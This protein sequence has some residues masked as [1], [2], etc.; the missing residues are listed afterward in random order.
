VRSWFL[1][2]ASSFVINY[3]HRLSI[4]KH[5]PR[6]VWAALELACCLR[7]AAMLAVLYAG[8]FHWTRAVEFYVL[9][10]FVLGLNYNR[11]LVA[12]HYRNRGE[13]M[14]HQQ[15]LEDSVNITGGGLLT[16]LFFPL[17]LRYHALHHLFPSIP[18]HNLAWAHERLVRQ[19][20]EDSLY[21]TT[22]FASY[23][24]VLAELWA[25]ARAAGTSPNPAAA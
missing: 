17:G 23:W 5:A 21:H 13:E 18:Y 24:D 19:L 2:H 8:V 11:N 4:S 16:E 25:D 3:R 7:A 10:M 22:I 15:Q 14:S 9:A 6:R 20:P 12:H 1:E